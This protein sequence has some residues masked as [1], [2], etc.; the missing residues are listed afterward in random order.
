MEAEVDTLCLLAQPKGQQQFKKKKQ[1]ELTEN[2]TVCKSDNQGDKETFINRGRRGGDG[3]PGRRGLA[4]RQWLVDPVRWADAAAPH[5]HTD[6]LEGTAGN[7]SRLHN[8]VWG[9][10]ASDL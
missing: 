9:N 5:S 2:Q 6:K 8:P 1:P 7:Q 10:K 4:A 3:Q